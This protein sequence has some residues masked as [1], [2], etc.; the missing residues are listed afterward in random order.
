MV[1]FNATH[2]KRKEEI[3]GTPV[4]PPPP[5]SQKTRSEYLDPLNKKEKKGQQEYAICNQVEVETLSRFFFAGGFK[6][7]VVRQVA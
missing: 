3:L 4:R 2:K 7:M 1:C 6:W 5:L